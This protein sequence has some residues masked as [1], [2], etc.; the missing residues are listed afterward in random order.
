MNNLTFPML[1]ISLQ[2]FATIGL[3]VGLVSAKRRRCFTIYEH[4]TVWRNFFEFF[5]IEYKDEA[6]YWEFVRIF[7]RILMIVTIRCFYDNQ[8]VKIGLF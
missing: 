5:Y 2:I 7:E 3:L 8:F 1:V 6:Y 4:K